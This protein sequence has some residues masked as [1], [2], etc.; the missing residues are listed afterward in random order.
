MTDPTTPPVRP[1]QRPVLRRSSTDKVVGGVAGGLARTFDQDPV[2]VRIITVVLALAFPP[3]FIAYLAA[4]LLV[5]R[6]DEPSRSTT[7][8]IAFRETGGVLFWIGVLVLAGALIAAFDD[9]FTGRFDLL[10][11]VLLGIG[12]ALWTRDGTRSDA[13]PTP[14]TTGAAMPAT[15][16]PP[17]AP[18]AHRHRRRAVDPRWSEQ[19]PRP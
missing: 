2:V 14:T 7:G 18:G 12:V 4:W 11:L 6:D 13:A 1:A 15:H 8:G 19:A 16:T 5:A 17:A 3:A 10:P 9:P